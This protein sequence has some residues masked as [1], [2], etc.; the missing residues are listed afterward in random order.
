MTKMPEQKQPYNNF[1]GIKDLNQ[2]NIWS[3]KM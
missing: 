1:V 2:G 3:M